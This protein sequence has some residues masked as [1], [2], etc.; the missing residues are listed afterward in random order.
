VLKSVL[1]G[2]TTSSDE[3]LM[4]RKDKPITVLN[5][6]INTVKYATTSD[7]FKVF[8]YATVSEYTRQVEAVI[9]RTSLGF[10]I[11]YWRSL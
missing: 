4:S 11:H 10:T 8:S 1:R 3:I 2:K 9:E 7:Y 5:T 6:D